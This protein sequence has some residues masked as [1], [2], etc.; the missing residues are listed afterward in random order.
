[1]FEIGERVICI[2]SSMQPHT[3]EE[4]KKIYLIGW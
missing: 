4:L 3:T 2:D 1:M